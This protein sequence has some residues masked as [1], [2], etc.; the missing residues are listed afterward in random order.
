MSLHGQNR[1]ADG[2]CE[3]SSTIDQRRYFDLIVL[4]MTAFDLDS[5]AVFPTVHWR[6]TSQRGIRDTYSTVFFKVAL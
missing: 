6:N 1:I 3:E 5:I 2:D 4:T